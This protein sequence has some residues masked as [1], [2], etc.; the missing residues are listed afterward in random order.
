MIKFL[1]ELRLKARQAKRVGAFVRA[2]KIGM[3]DADARAHSDGLYPPTAEDIA[4]EEER[5]KR[6]KR[7]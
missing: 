4:Y 6:I 1:T 2:K 7:K 5:Q 3:S